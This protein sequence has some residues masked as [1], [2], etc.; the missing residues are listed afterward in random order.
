[1]IMYNNLL[2]TLSCG[3]CP[4]RF[5]CF[6]RKIP[7]QR[8]PES[9]QNFVIHVP[10]K[11]FY[12]NDTDHRWYAQYQTILNQITEY[13]N[14]YC[15]VIQENA[16]PVL[17]IETQ[18][19][20]DR[21]FIKDKFKQ[22]LEIAAKTTEESDPSASIVFDGIG[23]VLA[24]DYLEVIHKILSILHTHYKMSDANSNCCTFVQANPRQQKSDSQK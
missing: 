17:S 6:L 3:N 21:Q 19:A 5:N 11:A 24:S 16:N 13:Y 18:K 14:V 9:T 7:L 22:L 10:G 20:S 12:F 4:S 2:N 23:V 15:G 1:M 8:Y